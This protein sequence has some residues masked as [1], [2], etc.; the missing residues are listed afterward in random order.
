[1]P[2]PVVEQALREYGLRYN[3]DYKRWE[4][5]DYVICDEDIENFTVSDIDQIIAGLRDGKD[6]VPLGPGKEFRLK[7]E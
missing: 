7:F 5:L 3:A 4:G 2:L 6:S 1:M